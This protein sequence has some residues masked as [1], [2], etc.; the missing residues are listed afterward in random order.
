MGIVF[1][2][3]GTKE[4]VFRTLQS[5]PYEIRCYEPFLVAEVN[6]CVGDNSSFS[7]LAKYIGVF[8]DPANESRQPMDMTSPVLV[9]HSK[10]AMTSPVISNARDSMGFVMP[11]E[12]TSISQLPKP[13]DPR[14]ELKA[15]PR[16][17]IAVRRFSGWYSADAGNHH[18]NS[19]Y[20]LLKKD[21]HV[22]CSKEAL[23]WSVAQYHPPFTIPFL[24]R[25]EVWVALNAEN[26]EKLKEMLT[27]TAP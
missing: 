2:F 14:I 10:L 18:L 23:E 15:I 27:E 11:F 22:S 3:T 9:E 7:V 13:K 6:S 5:V 26:N 8:G 17:L 12:Y 21:E 24:R 20:D 4:P 19:L 25:N 1:G 16:R